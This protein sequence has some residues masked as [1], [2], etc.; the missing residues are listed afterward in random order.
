MGDMDDGSVGGSPCRIPVLKGAESRRSVWMA[1]AVRTPH[2]LE[3]SSRFM[4]LMDAVSAAFDGRGSSSL[5]TV[6]GFLDAGPTGL[7]RSSE[8]ELLKVFRSCHSGPLLSIDG[9][10]S[11]KCRCLSLLMRY[12]QL[13]TAIRRSTKRT[14]ALTDRKMIAVFSSCEELGDVA[15]RSEESATLSEVDFDMFIG[16]VEG[17]VWTVFKLKDVVKGIS[18]TLADDPEALLLFVETTVV[19]TRLIVVRIMINIVRG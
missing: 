4:S 19:R 10:A 5:S 18:R 8:K 11:R 12:I 6:V 13:P 14:I 3:S 17:C 2:I 1:L 9:S 15:E 16:K 7:F